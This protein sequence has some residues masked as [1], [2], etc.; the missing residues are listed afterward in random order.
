MHVFDSRPT[1]SDAPLPSADVLIEEAH[2]RHRR[3]R[4]WIAGIVLLVAAMGSVIGAVVAMGTGTPSA[5]TAPIP[6][7]RPLPATLADRGATTAFVSD[8]AGLVPIDLNTGKLQPVI[9]IAGLD[10]TANVVSSPNGQLAYVV[11]LGTPSEPGVYE[12]GPQLIPVNLATRQLGAPIPFRASAYSSGTG[13]YRSVSFDITDLAI[14]PDG[15]TVLVADAADHAVIPINVATHRIE[16]PIVLPT[17]RTVGSL[18]AGNAPISNYAPVQPA[19]L[20][21]LAVDPNGTTAYVT[22]GYVVVPIDLATHRALAPITGFEA[23]SQIAIDPSGQYAYVTSAYCWSSDNTGKC[24]PTPTHPVTEPNGRIQLYA[25]GNEVTVVDLST[26][27]ITQQLAVGT[28]AM[29]TGVAVSPDGTKVYV[30]Y[31]IYGN[32]GNDIT[33]IDARTNTIERQLHDALP[34]NRGDGATYISINPKGNEAF[35]T[36]FTVITPGPAGP[37]TFRGAVLV[38]LATGQPAASVRFG[39]P[40]KYGE[41]TGPVLFGR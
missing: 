7:A 12:T 36:G 3:R 13:Q 28:S 8:A 39:A 15:K 31:G 30:T 32:H 24:V 27:K 37:V 2:Q 1:V 41:S 4:R 34:A 38:N 17:E 29:P 10:A 23:P 14:T 11:S 21:G 18:I 16:R 5:V 33:V 26:N 40:V 9:R 25:A 22:D 6:I 20:G 35:V 19:G